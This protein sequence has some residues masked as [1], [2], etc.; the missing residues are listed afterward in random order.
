MDIGPVP[1]A[2]I[3]PQALAAA[4]WWWQGRDELGAL[5][6]LQRLES[7]AAASGVPVDVQLARLQALE[8][9]HGVPPREAH[10]FGLTQEGR[11]DE[12][13]SYL[14]DIER[15]WNLSASAVLLGAGRTARRDATLLSDKMK[16]ADVLARVG[17][18]V[19][20]SMPL[21][22]PGD[23]AAG[24]PRAMAAWGSTF[25]KPR[26]GSGGRGAAVISPTADGMPVVTSYGHGRQG[27]P[28]GWPSLLT[29]GPLLLQPLLQ[30]PDWGGEDKPH[31]IT[32]VR[33]V[34]RNTA[35]GRGPVVF[36][37]V[38]ELPQPT[39]YRM[40]SLED[41]Q[42]RG[43]VLAERAWGSSN[44][45]LDITAVQAWLREH[46]WLSEAAVNAHLAFSGLFAIAWDMAVTRD[47][48]IFLEGNVGFGT[49]APQVAAGGLLGDL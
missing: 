2:G 46:S 10:E 4:H 19:V 41:G 33:V 7:A 11:F 20:S 40:L 14:Y 36:S 16:T 47:G 49:L 48:P 43:D 18:P 6:S 21:N 39:G 42:V 37:Q 29:H 44:S 17:L 23:L 35:D 8:R 34:T 22:D 24:L 32:T 38:L 9:H 1:W 28:L 26:F 27:S 13:P 45:E 30:S 3:V 12:W 15:G 31:D 5:P 25:V